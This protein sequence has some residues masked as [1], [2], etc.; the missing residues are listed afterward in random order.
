ME[1]LYLHVNVGEQKFNEQKNT[2]DLESRFR[3]TSRIAK[4]L[5]KKL[6][7]IAQN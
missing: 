4:T 2:Q 7:K 5:K 6:L 1:L 3:F